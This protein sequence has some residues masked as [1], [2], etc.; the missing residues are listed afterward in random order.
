MLEVIREI[1][2]I[3]YKIVTMSYESAVTI[4]LA[5]VTVMLAAIGLMIGI[6][7]IWG[8]GEMRNFLRT[9][10]ERHVTRVMEEKLGEYPKPDEL[11]E[12][13]KKQLVIDTGANSVA[14]ASNSEVQEGSTVAPPYPEGE[15]SNARIGETGVPNT[16]TSNS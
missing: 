11:L 12:M 3:W 16:G 9:A 1:I 2:W 10:A 14:T 15:P 4:I 6:I 8:F 5:A 13:Y 7:A